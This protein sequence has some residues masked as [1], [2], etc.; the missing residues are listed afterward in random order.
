MLNNLDWTGA[1]FFI[2]NPSVLLMNILIKE[3]F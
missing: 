1:F 3:I 2:L